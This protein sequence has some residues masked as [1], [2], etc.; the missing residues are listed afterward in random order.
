MSNATAAAP[1]PFTINLEWSTTWPLY[2]VYPLS[3]AF[4]I[5]LY[6]Y[7][8]PKL[9]PKVVKRYQN[10]G[11]LSKKCWRQNTNALLHTLVLCPMLF[12][13]IMLDEPMRLQRPL[14]PHHNTLGYV[15]LCWSLGY[16]T[17]TIPWSY[18]LYWEGERHA[19]NL[20]LCIHHGVVYVA[21]LTYLIARTAA[22][23]GAVAF[24]AMECTNVFFI[25]HILQQSVRSKMHTLWNINYVVLVVFGVIGCRLTLCTYMFV[26]FSYDISE[27]TSESPVEWTFVVAQYVIFLFVVL[28][29][30][31][32][33][34]NGIKDG[35]LDKLLL[36]KLGLE[37]KLGAATHTQ[38]KDKSKDKSKRSARSLATQ[39]S[40]ASSASSTSPKP[41]MAVR[42]DL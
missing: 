26:L 16:F 39:S 1:P 7:I 6:A 13:A 11:E 33:I 20:A 24:A 28:L 18:K 4:F 38:S 32:F 15:A 3:A 17:F 30:W 41:G 22:L 27:F 29:S 14:H 25:A 10:M 31:L 40:A 9:W 36:K 2:T 34:W 19:T 37:G 12:I 35:G 42:N 21:A 8:G 5:V 23:Y